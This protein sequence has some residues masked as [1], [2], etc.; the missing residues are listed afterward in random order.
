MKLM[1]CRVNIR[2]NVISIHIQLIK[3]HRFI[4]NRTVKMFF[5]Q[6]KYSRCYMTTLINTLRAK[7]RYIGNVSVST[8]FRRQRVDD[9]IRPIHESQLHCKR[10]LD[11]S[12]IIIEPIFQAGIRRR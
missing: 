2:N 10:S 7:P 9:P 12:R 11:Q 5:M 3:I 1:H 8:S 6:V 4:A